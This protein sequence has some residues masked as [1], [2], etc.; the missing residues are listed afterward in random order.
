MD[1]GRESESVRRRMACTEL[2]R[3]GLSEGAVCGRGDD[4][5]GGCTGRGSISFGR[6]VVSLML[7]AV[8]RG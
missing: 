4:M 7:T 3:K 2:R 8:T 5:A 1:V 6:A